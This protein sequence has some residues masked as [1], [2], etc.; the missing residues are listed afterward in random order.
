[1]GRVAPA[2]AQ[3]GEAKGTKDVMDN[4]TPILDRTDYSVVWAERFPHETDGDVLARVSRNVPVS[5]T[6]E[7]VRQPWELWLDD[8]RAYVEPRKVLRGG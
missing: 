7:M 1:V 3:V 2:V 8:P 5:Q 4:R 6:S